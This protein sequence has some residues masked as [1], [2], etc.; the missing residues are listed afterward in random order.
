MLLPSYVSTDIRPV[1]HNL[2]LIPM[3]ASSTIHIVVGG[4]TMWLAARRTSARRLA[5][6]AEI[7]FVYYLFS[8]IG[9]LLLGD[10]MTLRWIS[11]FVLTLIMG[12]CHIEQ[13][14][15]VRSDDE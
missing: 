8:T 12:V 15:L 6:A 5:H 11:L 13:K 10:P 7:M 3:W 1:I 2:L 14:A 4:V 9:F